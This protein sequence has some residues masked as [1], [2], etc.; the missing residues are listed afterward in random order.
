MVFCVK[1]VWRTWRVSFDF[2]LT[3]TGLWSKQSRCHE[4][5]EVRSNSKLWVVRSSVSV[6]FWYLYW[7]YD[8]VISRISRS[9]VRK[10][11]SLE[12]FKK[13]S[14][15]FAVAAHHTC[16]SFIQFCGSVMLICTCFVSMTDLKALLSLSIKLSKRDRSR[17]LSLWH[18]KV[19]NKWVSRGFQLLPGNA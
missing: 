8:G 7:N 14:F 15:C 18:Q 3:S 4:D 11:K 12:G 5:R 6:C 1:S 17:A 16:T 13:W 9:S 2:V 19:E 10:K